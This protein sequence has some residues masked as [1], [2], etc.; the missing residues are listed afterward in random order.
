MVREDISPGYQVSQIVHSALRFQNS[1]PELTN[2]WLNT[3]ETIVCLGIKNE[4]ELI[5]LIQ[6]A[7]LKKIKYSVFREPDMDNQITSAVFEPG[8]KSGK[9]CSNLGLVLRKYK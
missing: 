8:E 1:F 2:N 7:E 4:E 9:L 5:K 3:S 6:K